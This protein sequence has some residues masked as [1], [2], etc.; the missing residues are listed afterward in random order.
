MPKV[1]GGCAARKS[2]PIMKNVLRVG[3]RPETCTKCKIRLDIPRVKVIIKIVGSVSQMLWYVS[4]PGSTGHIE[5]RRKSKLKRRT[6][7]AFRI[8][9]VTKFLWKQKCLSSIFFF[10]FGLKI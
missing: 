6:W 8:V 10:N 9:R 2:V 1:V 7:L 5:W 3:R 4:T